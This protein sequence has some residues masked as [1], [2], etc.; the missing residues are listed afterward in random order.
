MTFTGRAKDN[1]MTR[2]VSR[3]KTT[4]TCE[5]NFPRNKDEQDNSGFDHPVN[6]PWKQ[7]WFIAETEKTIFYK[8][9]RFKFNIITQCSS[10]PLK[11]ESEYLLYQGGAIWHG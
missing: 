3:V 1:R 5:H 11:Y 9:D 2:F 4:L 6:Q 8:H 10:V 7:L